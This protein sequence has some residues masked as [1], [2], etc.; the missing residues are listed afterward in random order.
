MNKGNGHAIGE[1]LKLSDNTI[2]HTNEKT[3]ER[4][5]LCKKNQ[6]VGEPFYLHVFDHIQENGQY[7]EMLCKR[8]LKQQGLMINTED[9]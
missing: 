5:Y 7:V 2:I 1:L 9:K 4:C 3:G 6:R 8:C